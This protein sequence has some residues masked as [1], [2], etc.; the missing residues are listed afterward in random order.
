MKLIS[1]L[2]FI[3]VCLYLAWDELTGFHGLYHTTDLYSVGFYLA[4]AAGV[5]LWGV[6]AL[7]VWFIRDIREWARRRNTPKLT[8]AQEQAQLD[9]W[10]AEHGYW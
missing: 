10:R 6:G 2:F 7:L 9:A 5:L 8:A 3:G 1:P 4:M